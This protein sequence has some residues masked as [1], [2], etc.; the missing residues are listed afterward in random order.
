M[1][2]IFRHTLL[3]A[4]LVNQIELVF[5]TYGRQCLRHASFGSI[6]HLSQATA[7]YFEERNNASTL[8]L[9]PA[10]GH[11]YVSLFMALN[12]R[13]LLFSAEGNDHATVDDYR[14]DP[15]AHKGEA[16]RSPEAYCGRSQAFIL[17]L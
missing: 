11:D 3:R 10:G 1:V 5:R 4:S 8:G 15:E 17:G 13:P 12:R 16:E 6:T 2:S 7:A 9:R 14:R